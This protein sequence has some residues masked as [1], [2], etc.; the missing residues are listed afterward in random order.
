M[1]ARRHE[2]TQNYDNGLSTDRQ[3]GNRGSLAAETSFRVGH[4]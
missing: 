1:V 4:A 3:L 2:R